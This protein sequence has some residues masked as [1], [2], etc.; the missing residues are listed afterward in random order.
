MAFRNLWRNS[1]R[2]LLTI[3]AIAFASLLL[4]FMLS[5]QFGSYGMMI[6]AMVK[7]QAGHLQ[8][9]EK[10]YQKNMDIQKYIAEPE[11][12]RTI[13]DNT[14]GI[15]AYTFRCVAFSLVSSK[16]RSYAAMIVGI[17]PEKEKTVSSLKSFIRKGEYLSQEDTDQALIGELLAKNLRVTIGDELTLLGQGQDGSIAATVVYVKGIYRAGQDE[18]DRSLIHI[19]M[20]CFQDVYAMNGGV[21]QAVIIAKSLLSVSTIKKTITHELSTLKSDSNLVALDWN[22]LIPGLSQAISMDLMSGM[23][24]WFLLTIVVAFSILNTFLMTIFERKKEFGV[25]MAIGTSPLRLTRL[26]LNES[27]L[28]TLI[29]VGIG[30]FL[31]TVIT[32]Y[33]QNHGID[34][35]EAGELL[36]QYG[37]AGKLYPKLSLLTLLLGPSMVTIVTIVSSLYPAIKLKRLTPVQAMTNT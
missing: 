11:K 4:V 3:G 23:I 15:T 22:E 30:M 8:I 6:E 12:I 19:P 7:M 2:T 27:V 24:F 9:Q 25:M 37:I 1:R 13:L 34:L 29:G 5:V 36:K 14:N 18:F 20:M 35:G 17:D 16:E 28:M 33:F 10:D 26:I 31:G 21:H 32:L